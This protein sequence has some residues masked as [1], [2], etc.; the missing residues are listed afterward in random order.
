MPFEL[1][2][3]MSVRGVSLVEYFGVE[4][5]ALS[6]FYQQLGVRASGFGLPM[7][8]P[9][10]IANTHAALMLTE[11][12]GDLGRFE[13]LRRGIFRCYFAEGRNLADEAVLLDCAERSGLHPE[14]GLAS[15]MRPRYEDR[16]DQARAEAERFG[17][18]GTPTWVVDG[19]YRAVGA[20]PYEL[21]REGLLRIAAG[22]MPPLPFLKMWWLRLD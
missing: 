3:D 8:L 19:L 16:L 22:G 4:A 20:Q 10:V 21:L 2:P 17:V 15:V 11:Y 7:R 13:E 9:T 1:H 12:A 5:E 18:I 14:S 6:R